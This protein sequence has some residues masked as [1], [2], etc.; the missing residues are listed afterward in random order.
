[1]ICD[2]ACWQSCPATF[3]ASISGASCDPMVEGLACDY[4]ADHERCTCTSGVF[5]CATI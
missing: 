5:A 3:R 1:M 2:D 4:A